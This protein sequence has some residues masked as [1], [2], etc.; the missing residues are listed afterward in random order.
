MESLKAE[1]RGFNVKSHVLVEPHEKAMDRFD[2]AM[3]R[4]DQTVG[5]ML[6]RI[7]GGLERVNEKTIAE[8]F[9]SGLLVGLLIAV[10]FS[11]VR[12]VN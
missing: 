8:T 1:P 2:K 10:L 11:V 4:V 9:V 7:D 5:K 12:R 6:V 3:D